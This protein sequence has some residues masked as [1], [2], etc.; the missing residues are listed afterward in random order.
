MPREYHQAYEAKYLADP[1]V[2]AR[3]AAQMRQYSKSPATRHHHVA[4]W[5]VHRALEAGRLV[6]Q[7]CEVCGDAK[8]H[9]HHD[10]YSKPLDVRWLCLRHHV[11]HHA[12]ATGQDGA[13]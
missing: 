7:P 6:K 1:S 2:K 8:V 3:R 11:D 9:A 4:R 10:D 5:Q 13:A 12:K